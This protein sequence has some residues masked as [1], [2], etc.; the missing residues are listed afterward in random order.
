MVASPE[1][2]VRAVFFDAGNTL[3]LM[4]YAA[5]AARLAA[6]GVDTSPEAVERAEWRARVRLDRQVLAR[7][8]STESADTGRQYVAFLLDALG[9]RDAATARALADWRRAWN[10]PFGPWTRATPTAGAAIAAARAAGARAAVISNSDGHVR[11]ILA[12]LGLV[13]GLDFVL[14]SSEVGVEKP[15]PRIFRIAVERA[16]VRPEEAAYIGDLY[17]VDVLGARAAGLRAV[18]LDPGGDWGA[19]DCPTAPTTL[20]AV[21]I[22]DPGAPGVPGAPPSRA[23]ARGGPGYPGTVTKG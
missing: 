3:I 15:D 2:P 22:L 21:R 9:V 17:S 6:L 5:I 20:A 8:V 19:L 18:L 13:A 10:P 7:R 1:P 11:A 4:D 23:D 16:G 12:R 14:D